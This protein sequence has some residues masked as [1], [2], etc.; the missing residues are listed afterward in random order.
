MTQ[1]IAL[2]GRKG[3]ITKTTLTANI[4]A[5]L[6]RQGKRVVAIETDGQGQLSMRMDIQ[7]HDGFYNLIKNGAA[8]DDVLVS[9]P[10]SF[11]D[12]RANGGELYI[13]SAADLQSLMYED[14]GVTG[15]IYKRFQQMRGHVDYVL[16]DTSPDVNEINNAW[17]YVADW[18]VLPT[19]CEPASID[20]LRLQTVK[21]IEERQ[22]YAAEHNLPY[23]RILGIVPNR[24]D[25]RY[26]V[27]S[28][29][30][31]RLQG[32]YSDRYTVYDVMRNLA[33]WQT[34]AFMRRSIYTYADSD[35]LSTAARRV[36]RQDASRAQKELQRVIDG[37]I[38]LEQKEKVSA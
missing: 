11:A 10:E 5:G 15:V 26:I 3:G 37:I 28:V 19:L 6:A 25:S 34:S 9:P 14:E 36:A 33:T 1:I 2:I 35:E 7:R 30:V 13:I 22:R 18:L 16:V 17:F 12:E 38:G 29:C 24:Y 20:T 21:Y 32:W 4:A 23:A 8:F 31:G 27:Q